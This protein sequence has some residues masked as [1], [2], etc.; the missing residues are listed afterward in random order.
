MARHEVTQYFDDI[1]N[2]PLADEDVNV[3]DFTI[4]GV[5]YTMELGPKNKKE[6]DDALAPYL[7]VARRVSKSSRGK[8]ANSSSSAARN[9]LIREWAQSNNIEVSKRG[10]IAADVIQKFNKAHQ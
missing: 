2:S 4:D 10:R 6:F 5:D 3:V 7:A 9:K 8:A 1:D